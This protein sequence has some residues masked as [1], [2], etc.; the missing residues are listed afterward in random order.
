MAQLDSSFQQDFCKLFSFIAILLLWQTPWTLREA[1][2]SQS[3]VLLGIL[4]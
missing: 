1:E 2:L 4:P 3:C